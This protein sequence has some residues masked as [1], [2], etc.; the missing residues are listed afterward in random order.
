MLFR[1]DGK[2]NNNKTTQ[3]K[4]VK[5]NKTAKNSKKSNSYYGEPSPTWKEQ[6]LA[7]M[8]DLND[9]MTEIQFY[10][11]LMLFNEQRR[12]LDEKELDK[13]ELD[14]KE[15]DEMVKDEMEKD[16]EKE[17]SKLAK[18]GSQTLS[19]WKDQ[20]KECEAKI[21]ELE[22]DASDLVEKVKFYE[23]NSLFVQ[24][25]EE[26]CTIKSAPHI[27][28]KNKYHVYMTNVHPKLYEFQI[29]E[30]YISNSKSLVR[31][32][33]EFY[34]GHLALLGNGPAAAL[35]FSLPHLSDD[36]SPFMI[37]GFLDDVN[38]EYDYDTNKIGRAHV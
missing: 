27:G 8:E 20:A 33:A 1:S 15:K 16:E 14:E 37:T 10:N 9:I 35:S 5:N 26:G 3:R 4:L 12:K 23:N 36:S 6:A 21:S 13:K 22:K 34:L 38:L 17:D 31:T 19:D 2:E 11:A 24:E 30:S 28:S 25:S 32:S 29:K 18:F 7:C